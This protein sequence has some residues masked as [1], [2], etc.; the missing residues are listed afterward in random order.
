MSTHPRRRA[1]E[2]VRVR[3]RKRRRVRV[4]LRTERTGESLA[5]RIE[6]RS[7]RHFARRSLAVDSLVRSFVVTRRP[8]STVRP[9]RRVTMRL[10]CD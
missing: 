8:W 6:R 10:M 9:R 7:R 5:K 2:T 4:Q 3:A 1:L